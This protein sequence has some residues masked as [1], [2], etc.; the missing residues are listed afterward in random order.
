RF[1]GYPVEGY[2]GSGGTFVGF[3][4]LKLGLLGGYLVE[5]LL[6]VELREHLPFADVGVDVGIELGDDAAGLGFDLN[7]GDRLH[8]AG[9]NHG[10]G[11]VAGGDLG[12]LRGVDLGRSTHGLDG[13]DGEGGDRDQTDAE[14]DPELFAAFALCRQGESLPQLCTRGGGDWFRE[15]ENRWDE[16]WSAPLVGCKAP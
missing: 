12:E 10:A 14:A 3:G 15:G 2:P 9:R 16:W 13:G 5:D 6:L 7:L 1:G 11:D 4:G 8:L